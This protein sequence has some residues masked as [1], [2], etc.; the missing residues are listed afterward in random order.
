MRKLLTAVLLST[1]AIAGA[2]FAKGERRVTNEEVNRVIDARL[3]L[4]LVQLN[5]KAPKP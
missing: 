5:H 4:M 2:T 1:V 3:H